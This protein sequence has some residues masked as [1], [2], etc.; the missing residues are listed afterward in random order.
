MR[1]ATTLWAGLGL[2]LL[3]LG[4]GPARAERPRLRVLAAASLTEVVAALGERFA[5]AALEAS[6]AASSE[7]A[8]QI[9]DGAPADVFLS[10]SPEWTELL[11]ERGGLAAEPVVFARNRLVCIA[12]RGGALAA[13]G[14]RDLGALA[15][16][17][18]PGDLVAIADAGV[19]AGEY[20]RQSLAAAGL[21]G[22]LR[23]QLV[24]RK[25]VRAVLQ[26]VES[27]EM[28]AGFAYATD[29]RTAEVAVLF[30]LDP[31]S[32]AP[33]AYEAAVVAGS[34]S[35]PLAERFLAFLRSE[36]AQEVLRRAGFT[37]PE[38]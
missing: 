16:A 24:G 7:L 34:G 35:R 17:L 14:V 38:P 19:P 31:R 15:D 8:R 12:P 25:D 21:E 23:R 33:I 9:A 29:A 26:S 13:R 5:P 27:G 4:T 28:N 30:A 2:A 6:F 18:A 1:R 37:P 20:A 32:H 36:P 10:A 3:L 11:R 22:R